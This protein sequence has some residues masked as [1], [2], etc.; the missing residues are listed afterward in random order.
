MVLNNKN[1]LMFVQKE[2]KIPF[3][4]KSHKRSK[5]IWSLS[6]HTVFFNSKNKF[7]YLF[8]YNLFI[9]DKNTYT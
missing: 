5:G 4:V 2:K 7:I 9:V 8:I 3:L 6:D 1:V